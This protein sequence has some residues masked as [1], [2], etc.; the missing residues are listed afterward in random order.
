MGIRGVHGAPP[1]LSCANVTFS[2]FIGLPKNETADSAQ[3]RNRSTVTKPLEGG[4]R[5][6]DSA[7]RVRID[8]PTGLAMRRA[9]Q[10]TQ[11]SMHSP[12]V[13]THY[14]GSPVGSVY[15]CGLARLHCK[16]GCVLQLLLQLLKGTHLATWLCAFKIIF[17][18][19]QASLLATTL[20]L[21]VVRAGSK[22]PSLL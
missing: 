1:L 9:H 4:V 17:L 6:R 13:Y 16:M 21:A 15:V 12:L 7:L 11:V 3:P 8:D 18:L 14:R 20:I 2:D 19:F 10:H 5:G 22:Q